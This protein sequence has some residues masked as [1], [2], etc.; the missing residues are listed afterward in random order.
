MC[1][2]RITGMI[3]EHA[4]DYGWHYH[5]IPSSPRLI[6]VKIVYDTLEKVVI[7]VKTPKVSVV[8]LA[9]KQQS[10]ISKTLFFSPKLTV[11]SSKPHVC[12]SCI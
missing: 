12:D 9:Y 1:L 4:P 11:D 3:A 2:I 10:Y 8:V 7:E 6:S 5:V